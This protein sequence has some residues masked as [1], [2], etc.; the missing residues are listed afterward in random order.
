MCQHY[1]YIMC[2]RGCMLSPMDGPRGS[3]ALSGGLMWLVSVLII[4][5]PPHKD[6]P[7]SAPI[8]APACPLDHD[9]GDVVVKTLRSH[10]V[11]LLSHS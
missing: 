1:V 11:T 2:T 8:Q 3:P 7:V 4:T 10:F 9:R 6:Q 5:I